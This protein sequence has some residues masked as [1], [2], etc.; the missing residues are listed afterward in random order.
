MTV[1]KHIQAF[2]LVELSVVLVIIGILAGGIIAGQELMHNAVIRAEISDIDKYNNA[3]STFYSKYG[4]LPGD[5]NVARAIEFHLSNAGDANATGAAGYRDGN[6]AIEGGCYGCTNL[7]GETALVWQDL[8]TSGFLGGSYTSTG[9][10]TTSGQNISQGM[11]PKFLPASRLQEATSHFLYASNGRNF[12]FLAAFSSDASAQ[13]TPSPTVTPF[14]ANSMDEK[15]DDG[16]PTT[17]IVLAMKDL[18]TPD[19]GAAAAPTVCVSNSVTPAMY[20]VG[21]GPT[22]AADIPL[23]EIR[24]RSN[25]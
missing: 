21:T 14:D 12:Y 22:G 3:M 4:G 7:S 6:G 23:C 10:S 8:G 16:F 17:G 18:S 25:Y 9:A 20:N 1:T 11:M 13:M 5:L 24:I 15:M 2:T 19:N